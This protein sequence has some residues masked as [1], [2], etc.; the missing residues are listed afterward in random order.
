MSPPFIAVFKKSSIM[1]MCWKLLIVAILSISHVLGSALNISQ[2]K[3]EFAKAFLESEND[4]IDISV[5][6]ELFPF[7]KAKVKNIA[8]G[9]EKYA[10]INSEEEAER[11][12]LDLHQWR[13]FENL[14]LKEGMSDV[15]DIFTDEFKNLPHS[16]REAIL[17]S[18][19]KT[20]EDLKALPTSWFSLLPS[21]KISAE[22]LVDHFVLHQLD[23]PLNAATLYKI[24]IL[25][26]KLDNQKKNIMLN[27]LPE[28]VL[29]KQ[30]NY[31]A[32]SVAYVI[33]YRWTIDS[34]TE[35]HLPL[36][37][38]PVDVITD[39]DHATFHKVTSAN[40]LSREEFGEDNQESSNVW[41]SKFVE[42]I[43][44]DNMT[45]SAENLARYGHLL[46][47]ATL[48]DLHDLQHRNLTK[49]PEIQAVLFDILRNNS[50][51]PVRVSLI[52][53]LRILNSCYLLTNLFTVQAHVLWELL[54][55][56]DRVRLLTTKA[57]DLD[58]SQLLD[59]YTSSSADEFAAHQ[60][61]FENSW[62][63]MANPHSLV[64]SVNALFAGLKAMKDD[65]LEKWTTEDIKNYGKFI[66]IFSPDEI[67][68]L[69]GD[70]V[71][72]SHEL[73]SDVVSP[74]L[75]LSQLTSIYKRYKAQNATEDAEE[76]LHPLL[77]S[78]LSSADLMSP[79][80]PFIW[81]RDKDDILWA[82]VYPA[83]WNP[84]T[85][86]SIIANPTPHL[87]GRGP[88]QE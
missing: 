83:K 48:E 66:K 46:T 43:G 8:T 58:I 1:I 22:D 41:F 59:I 25:T 67:A 27:R 87:P 75:S 10:D 53:V 42:V 82:S 36:M 23:H 47:G 84:S 73:V 19:V 6:S 7:S 12:T 38:F 26:R 62:F 29:R 28:E 40:K 24:I 80:P 88:S 57:G 79:T 65:H 78:A 60:E 13:G 86:S 21:S 77:L 85:M 54:E 17:K 50:F 69:G 31:I 72:F 33:G 52:F 49:E 34:E 55:P 9:R 74:S 32:K 16:T 3:E 11:I 68:K 14:T 71:T 64:S 15:T 63:S 20:G 61:Q 18:K 70:N 76:S 30:V 37:A 5:Q 2:V 51:S 39:M 4:F 45:S 81:S 56:E 44:W 35:N